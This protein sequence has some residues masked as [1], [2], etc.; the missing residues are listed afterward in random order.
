MDNAP[1]NFF[2]SSKYFCT[3][4]LATFLGVLVLFVA[5]EKVE[6]EEGEETR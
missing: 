5:L 2:H 1:P 4:L 3:R 6:V